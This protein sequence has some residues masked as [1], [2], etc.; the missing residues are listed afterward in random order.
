MSFIKD[1]IEEA[2][3]AIGCSVAPLNDEDA[4]VIR[5]SIEET[6]AGSHGQSPLWER[7]EGDLS[8]HDPDGWRAIADF[9][10]EGRVTIFFD[11][12]NE[13][14]MYSVK[15]CSD[16]VN[17]LS[18]CPGFVFYLTD[19]ECSFLLCH[20]DHDYLIGAG[21]AKEWVGSR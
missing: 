20:N 8:K 11:R 16:V 18:E 17:L 14:T 5:K 7:L 19:G 15:S 10:F 21:A 9:P 1:A 2:Y 12:E 6:Y 4:M 3:N 13:T